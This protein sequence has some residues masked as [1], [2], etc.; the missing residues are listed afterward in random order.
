MQ[1]EFGD[2]KIVEAEAPSLPSTGSYSLHPLDWRKCREQFAKLFDENTDGFFFSH[3]NGCGENIATFLSKTEEV[4]DASY[5]IKIRSKFC[6]TNMPYAL[7]IMPSPFWKECSIRRSLMTILLRCG[8]FY[9]FDADN[10]E[11]ALFSDDYAKVTK[12]AI[13]RFLFGHIH[14]VK[15]DSSFLASKSGW[16]DLFAHKGVEEIRNKLTLPNDSTVE[17]TM[18]GLGTIWN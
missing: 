12:T 18:V 14:F 10:Y 7:W 1:V 13:Q 11:E 5:P 3:P 4:I 17:R 15:D 9:R 16:R 8:F 6:R 2:T